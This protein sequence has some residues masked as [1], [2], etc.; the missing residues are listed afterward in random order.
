MLNSIYGG[1]LYDGFIPE[2]I[3]VGI[4]YSGDNADYGAL[5]SMDYTPVHDVFIPG[6]GDAPKFLA[7]LKE[8]LVPFVE[9]NYH[10]Y[11]SQ[12]FLMRSPS[13]ARLPCMQRSLPRI[14]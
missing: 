2:M 13:A 1:L 7:F 3:I 8:E 6:S 4:T 12:R 9:N 14:F 10:T 11:P 5:R